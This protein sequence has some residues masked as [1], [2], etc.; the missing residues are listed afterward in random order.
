MIELFIYGIVL[1]N[2]VFIRQW[3]DVLKKAVLY[4]NYNIIPKNPRGL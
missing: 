4:K 3:L 1:K 2:S